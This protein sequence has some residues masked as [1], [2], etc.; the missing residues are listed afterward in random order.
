MLLSLDAAVA[1]FT[2]D[3]SRDGGHRRA[4][5]FVRRGHHNV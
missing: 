3:M 2:A 5:A 1:A 4:A